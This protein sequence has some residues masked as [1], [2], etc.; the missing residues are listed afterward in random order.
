L[1]INPIVYA[2]VSVSVGFGRIEDL[3]DADLSLVRPPARLELAL[4]DPQVAR[5]LVAKYLGLWTR[6]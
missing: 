4:L 3:E 6:R 1:A 2:E 5:E